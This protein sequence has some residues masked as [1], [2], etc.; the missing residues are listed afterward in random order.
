MSLTLDLEELRRCTECT[1]KDYSGEVDDGREENPESELLKSSDTSSRHAKV[2]PFPFKLHNMLEN[3]QQ[4]GLAHIV[5]WQPHGRC[6]LVRDQT[7]FVSEVMP[8]Y[9]N[10]SKFPS[11]QRQ[12]N[13]YGFRRLTFGQDKGA[14]YHECF[15]RG[16]AFLCKRIHRHKVKGNGVRMAAT[17]ESEP[18]F[19]DYR[20]YLP[21]GSSSKMSGVAA[22]AA[23]SPTS[24][25]AVQ[26][27]MATLSMTLVANPLAPITTSQE[28]SQEQQQA[29][30]NAAVTSLA[31]PGIVAPPAMK[32][33]GQDGAATVPFLVPS[34]LS[35]GSEPHLVS[36][37]DCHSKSNK[38]DSTEG[39]DDVHFNT[40]LNSI[41]APDED[42]V[43]LSNVEKQLQDLLRTDSVR[44]F[45]ECFMDD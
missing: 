44:D 41:D 40:A 26:Q 20:S 24:P 38:S 3:I 34:L 10:M 39:E 9:F 8:R 36:D 22:A 6:F 45:L 18:N 31:F 14:Y 15:L 42:T 17:P 12:L 43:L 25:T 33:G 11:F 4:D 23:I 21:V 29:L 7:A 19:Y 5:S 13:L 1:Y 35:R 30:W 2:L 28:Q 37:D 32:Q 16:K 27:L